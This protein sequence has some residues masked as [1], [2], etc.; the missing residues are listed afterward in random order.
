MTWETRRA[1]RKPITVQ[2]HVRV[3]PAMKETIQLAK[4]T[5]EAQMVDISSLGAGLLAKTYLPPGAL[6]DFDLPR[7]S[8]AAGRTPPLTGAIKIT[9]RIV[10]TKAEGALCRM[11]VEFTRIDEI[12]RLLIQQYAGK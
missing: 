9:G 1:P 7:A 12:D 6:I 5:V 4:E 8:L 3:N 11:G 10:H 2:V